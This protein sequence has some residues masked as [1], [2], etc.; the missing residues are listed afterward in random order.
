MNVSAL[1]TSEMLRFEAPIARRMPI[2]FWRSSTLMYVMT[3]IMTEDTTSEMEINAISTSRTTS[4]ISVTE[5]IS[6]PTASV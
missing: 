4:M 3:P 1:K 2:S 5:P 6:M